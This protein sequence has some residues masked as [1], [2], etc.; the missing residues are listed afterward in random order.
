MLTFYR[1][2]RYGDLG[3]I[4]PFV[5][6]LE[7]YMRMAR[8]PHETRIMTLSQM[9]ADG[10]RNMIPFVDEDGERM[11]DSSL[12][13]EH[14]QRMHNDPLGDLSLPEAEKHKALLIKKLCETELTNIM[15]YSRWLGSADYRPVAEFANR[16]REG[17]E[18]AFA[19]DKALEGVTALMHTFRIGRYDEETVERLL[20][21]DL[22]CLAFYLGGQPYFLGEKP[23]AVDASAFGLLAS[24]MHFPVAN[25]LIKVARE[26]DTLVAYCD[27]IKAE[28]FPSD[29]W[30]DPA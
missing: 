23:H 27:R 7:T 29:A 15:V 9:L 1:S 6:K 26:H 14:F 12:I 16:D 4:S 10:V 2:G 19:V 5:Y 28:F 24:F 22:D 13:I 21:E 17:D 18:L 8:I 11:G 20:R 30:A 3:D 25:R